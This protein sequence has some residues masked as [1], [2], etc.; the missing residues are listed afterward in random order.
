MPIS[1]T[2]ISVLNSYASGVMNRADH[3]ADEVQEIALVILGAII[4]RANS[5]SIK[6]RTMKGSPANMLWAEIGSKKFVFAY[7]H[8]TRKIEIRDRTQNG[9][10]LISMDNKTSLN[11]AFKFFSNL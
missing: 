3:H 2:D 6:I 10:V 5:D 7:N 8:E 9:N 11:E 4:W 1:A